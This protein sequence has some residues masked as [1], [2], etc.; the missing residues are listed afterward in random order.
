MQVARFVALGMRYRV[1]VFFYG[2]G[3]PLG[4][5][6]CFFTDGRWTR[7]YAV[8]VIV[9]VYLT[10]WVALSIG[11]LGPRNR[12]TA[13]FLPCSILLRV[14]FAGP[15]NL[16]PTNTLLPRLSALAIVRNNFLFCNAFPEITPTKYCPTSH[17]TGLKLSSHLSTHGRLSYSQMA[18]CRPMC[19]VSAFVRGRVCLLPWRLLGLRRSGRKFWVRRTGILPDARWSRIP[20]G[21]THR[22]QWLV[23]SSPRLI[24]RNVLGPP[25]GASLPLL[26]LLP[27]RARRLP[28]RK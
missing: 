6:L 20:C 19:L 16:P 5:V 12:Q 13:S 17:P 24:P 25:S 21:G 3:K 9:V 26:V 22:R 15:G 10:R 28:H 23:R 11:Q 27:P 7:F 18:M 2:A 14:K 1:I 4:T 8:F